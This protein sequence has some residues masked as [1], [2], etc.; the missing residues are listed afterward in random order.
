MSHVPLVSVIMP[1]FNSG[2]LIRASIESALQQDL[3]D[4]ELLVVDGGSVDNTQEIVSLYSRIDPRVRLVL[5]P[6]DKGPGHARSTGVR[7]A[8]GEYVAFLD[9][10]DLWLKRKLSVQIEFMRST[11]TNFSYTQYRMMNSRGT[12]T[13][14][15]LGIYCQYSY[16]TYF[17]LHG[18]GCST[19]VI[20]RTL[21]SEAILTGYGVELAEDTLLW[22]KILQSGAYA[23]GL[24]EALVLYRNTERS[25]SKSRLYNQLSLWRIYRNEF[26]L[27]RIHASTAYA[28][29]LADVA[30]RRF[31][32]SLC[33]MV[34]GKKQVSELYS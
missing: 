17:F 24:K 26:G 28:I 23:R 11:D 29:Y 20:K 30:L 22:L 4:L 7:H 8:R 15:P 13:S 27:S 1:A 10:D 9:A 33:T 19:V 18:I 25:L 16:A 14:C 12:E 21:F 31:S 34:S 6:D 32:C 2:R 5:N 3:K